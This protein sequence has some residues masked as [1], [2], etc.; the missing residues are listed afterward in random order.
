MSMLMSPPVAIALCANVFLVA[1]V[2]GWVLTA[3]VVT[4]VTNE[5]DSE[6]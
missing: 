6:S 5:E 3:C 4:Q 2:S 1:V